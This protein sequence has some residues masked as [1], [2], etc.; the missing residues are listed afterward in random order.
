MVEV[1]RDGMIIVK[2]SRG[3]TRLKARDQ[4]ILVW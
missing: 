4:R 2:G 1:R 3:C